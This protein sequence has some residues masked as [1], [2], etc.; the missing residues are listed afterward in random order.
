MLF[1]PPVSP[2]SFSREVAPIM[3]M[4]CNTCHG[5]AG[6]LNTRSYREIILGGN[7]GKVI[8]PG[9][10]DGSLLIHFVDGRRGT[11][12]RM[13]KGGRPL[14]PAQIDTLRRWIAEG[15]KDDDLPVPSHR[16]TR[17]DVPMDPRK[18]TRVF[19]RIDTEAYLTLRMLDPG[20]DRVLWS[21][22]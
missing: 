20:S 1:A 11:A 17:S 12:H 13:P 2:V 19:C 15:A 5:D 7:L 22:V 4:Y 18:V 10:P 21:E 16:I 9:D 14:S 8:L 6:G 3:A